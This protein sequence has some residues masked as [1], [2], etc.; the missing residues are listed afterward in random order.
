MAAGHEVI[1]P[2]LLTLHS[3]DNMQTTAHSLA[4]TFALLAYIPI[5]RKNFT[6]TSRRYCLTD[7]FLFGSLG[8]DNYAVMFMM[9]LQIYDDMPSLTYSSVSVA[10][11]WIYLLTF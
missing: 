11:T 6:S 3:A 4:F 7:E 8:K 5:N 10:L 1:H 2:E 9:F